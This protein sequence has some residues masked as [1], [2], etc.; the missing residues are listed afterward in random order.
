MHELSFLLL[1]V[2]ITVQITRLDADVES[3]KAL[4]PL[5]EFEIDP[6]FKRLLHRWEPYRDV[7]VEALEHP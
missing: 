2:F 6:T 7:A 1:I 4:G 5:A 3:L